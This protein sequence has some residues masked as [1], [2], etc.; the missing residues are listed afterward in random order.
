LLVETAHYRVL[1]YWLKGEKAGQTDTFM[2]NLPGFPNGISIRAD[3]SYWLGFSTKRNASL[4]KIH[5]KPAMK[6]LVYGLPEFLQP[7]ADQF[8]MVMHL[9][10]EGAILHTY[11]DTQGAVLS[12]AGAVKEHNGYLYIGG[13]VAPHIGKYKLEENL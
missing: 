2:D 5:P 12:E 3:G 11:F 10:G 1:R 9:S 8:G 4:D 6:K 7:K 13:D